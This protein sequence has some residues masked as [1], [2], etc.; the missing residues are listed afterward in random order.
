[1][2][3]PKLQS[4]SWLPVAVHSLVQIVVYAGALAFV[5][6]GAS[7]AGGQCS[8]VAGV[9]KL[10]LANI[11]S[12]SALAL[13]CLACKTWP[14]HAVLVKHMAYSLCLAEETASNCMFANY[15][16]PRGSASLQHSLEVTYPV[17]SMRQCT[18]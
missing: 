14:G 7:L 4:T 2:A 12:V 16:A 1:M 17:K 18:V 10:G 9:S 6:S 3:E 11:A 8:V 5:G 15:S 13:Q